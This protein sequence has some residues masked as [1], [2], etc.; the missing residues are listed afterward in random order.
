MITS[1]V[2]DVRGLVQA[3]TTRRRPEIVYGGM[4][5]QAIA[6]MVKG[7]SDIPGVHIIN[8]NDDWV[9]LGRSEI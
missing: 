8:D 5:W 6:D 1:E 4:T 3:Y 2:G 7:S 9:V